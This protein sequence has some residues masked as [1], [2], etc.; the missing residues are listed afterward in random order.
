MQDGGAEACLRA[1]LDEAVQAQDFVRAALLKQRIDE[2]RPAA[3]APQSS[4]L[5]A[6]NE[7]SA[8]ARAQA[9]LHLEQLAASQEQE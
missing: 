6:A 2:Q 4:Q 5:Q 3:H 7:A 9:T 1:E 8:Q